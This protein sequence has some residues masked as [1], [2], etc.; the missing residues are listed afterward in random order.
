MAAL[1]P[2]GLFL[3]RTSGA[4]SVKASTAALAASGAALLVVVG[5][6]G[7]IG[8][9]LV[10]GELDG[11]TTVQFDG[12]PRLSAPPLCPLWER[13]DTD[14]IFYQAIEAYEVPDERTVVLTPRAGAHDAVVAALRER[15]QELG[16]ASV[17][18]EVRD[19]PP[20]VVVQLADV[21]DAS[22]PFDL[23]DREV[24]PIRV[25]CPEGAEVPPARD[26]SPGGGDGDA[27]TEA[28]VAPTPS[29]EGGSTGTA[30][31]TREEAIADLTDMLNG[32]NVLA[33]LL[34]EYQLEHP[35]WACIGNFSGANPVTTVAQDERGPYLA[36]SEAFRDALDLPD[37]AWRSDAPPSAT[38]LLLSDLDRQPF[39]AVST[40]EGHTFTF[41]GAVVTCA[42][43]SP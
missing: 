39:P 33:Q 13:V 15:Q 11:G 18:A 42:T 25:P 6:L 30:I 7:L 37:G 16:S 27:D 20:N 1:A 9:L 10:R 5:G 28:E 36:P 2:L 41:G 8:V 29:A 23:L 24:A 4:L 43:L 32:D 14:I 34:W 19:E 31:L 35:T 3:R 21:G 26:A 40:S 12:Q 22:Q 38:T 17:V